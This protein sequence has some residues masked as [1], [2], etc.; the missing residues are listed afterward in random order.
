LL[1]RTSENQNIEND[2]S[3]SEEQTLE[4]KT[5]NDDGLVW[6]SGRNL[7]QFLLLERFLRIIRKIF[8]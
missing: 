4:I 5:D 2:Y 7:M 3:Q 6:F 1:T 8:Q